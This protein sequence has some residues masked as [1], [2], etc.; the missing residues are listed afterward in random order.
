VRV[1][2]GS[3]LAGR[4]DKQFFPARESA[5]HCYTQEGSDFERSVEADLSTLMARRIVELAAEGSWEEKRS[6]LPR[7]R[8][9]AVRA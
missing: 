4:V 2:D 8:V 5:Q 6:S 7:R 1:D 9:V 3:S